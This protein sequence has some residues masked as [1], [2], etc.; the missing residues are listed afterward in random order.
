MTDQPTLAHA[1]AQAARQ[2]QAARDSQEELDTIVQVARRSLDGINH[3]GVTLTHRDGRVQTQSAS[4]QLVL[5]LDQLQY[6]LREGPC[7]DAM[8]EA[9][10]VV[11]EHAAREPRWPRF[12]PQAL[13]RGL[14]AQMGVRLFI[15]EQILGGLNLYS[16]ESDTIPVDTQEM[17]VLFATHAALALGR[18]REVD[19]L[20]TAVS[21][22]GS[23]GQAIGILMV[24]YELDDDAAFQY[25]A[26]LSQDANRKLRDVAADIVAEVNAHHR[27]PGG[28][29]N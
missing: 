25:L 5:D 19:H 24:R 2:L 18:V 22:R 21:T 23:I 1:L 12:M 11:V 29:W 14:R 28:A 3:V 9:G 26:R 13:A 17:A 10:V 15:D 4:D 8:R 16:T 6:E 7:I 20:Q 27:R